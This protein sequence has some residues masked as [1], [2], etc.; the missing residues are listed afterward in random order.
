MDGKRVVVR[1]R[2]IILPPSE[3]SYKHNILSV[4]LKR[5]IKEKKGGDT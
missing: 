5:S 4:C 1:K 2:Y 3:N